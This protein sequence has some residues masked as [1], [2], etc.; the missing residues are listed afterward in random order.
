MAQNDVFILNQN[1]NQIVIFCCFRFCVF[2]NSKALRDHNFD[3]FD[4]R[5]SQIV[6][7]QANSYE[8]LIKSP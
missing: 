8:S 2:W 6:T 7:F 1:E 3:L 4:T 5:S